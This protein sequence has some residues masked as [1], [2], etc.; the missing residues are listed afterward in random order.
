MPMRSPATTIAFFSITLVACCCSQLGADDPAPSIIATTADPSAGEIERPT[1][2]LRLLVRL[3]ATGP[4][5]DSAIEADN[6]QNRR[7]PYRGSPTFFRAIDA[8]GNTLAERGF[9]LE[10]NIRSETTGEDGAMRAVRVPIDEPVF[11]VAVPLH[12]E[13]DSVRFFRAHSGEP[14]DTADLIGE[15]R[16]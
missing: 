6:T 4:Q 7:D 9:R 12:Q 16:P 13:L 11:S 3:T 2:M 5:I 10:T 14:R 1:R 8:D 15:I